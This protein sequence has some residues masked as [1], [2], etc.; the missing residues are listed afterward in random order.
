MYLIDTISTWPEYRIVL[1]SIL[2]DAITYDPGYLR[3]VA[4]IRHHRRRED[5]V[6]LLSI[7]ISSSK[8]PKQSQSRH[9]TAGSNY[10]LGAIVQFI[11]SLSSSS[12]VS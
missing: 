4:L 7:Q 10:F 8:Q 6:T 2:I 1:L 9:W 5:L 3:K 11:S 12:P